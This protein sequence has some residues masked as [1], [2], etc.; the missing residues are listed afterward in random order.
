MAWRRRRARSRACCRGDR[1]RQSPKRRDGAVG[2]APSVGFDFGVVLHIFFRGEGS[3]G[4]GGGGGGGPGCRPPHASCG[5]RRRCLA[6]A[7]LCT[8]MIPSVCGGEGGGHSTGRT[9]YAAPPGTSDNGARGAFHRSESRIRITPFRGRSRPRSDRAAPAVCP[10]GRRGPWGPARAAG[11]ARAGRGPDRGTDTAPA[12]PPGSRCTGP[13]AGGG[14]GGGGTSTTSHHK[15][16]PDA[17]MPLTC[18]GDARPHC[19]P[20]F[21]GQTGLPPTATANPSP[22]AIPLQGTRQP[23]L[24]R[25]PR[26]LPP[27]SLPRPPSISHRPS[28]HSSPP[29]GPCGLETG[30]PLRWLQ[31]AVEGLSLRGL[32]GVRLI[33]AWPRGGGCLPSLGPSGGQADPGVAKRR[34]MLTEFGAFW[35]S[36]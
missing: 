4:R 18:C 22:K 26:C 12:D 3:G 35:G 16:A 6:G 2:V 20:D 28:H 21:Y 34:G 29:I 27:A 1:A 33:Q 11:C 25:N 13:V 24:S 15:H 23:F 10:G 32:L 9:N 19:F 31:N 30:L 8:C 14:R 17:R 7:G 36:G 5:E